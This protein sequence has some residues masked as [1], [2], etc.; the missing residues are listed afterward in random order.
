MDFFARQD[1]ARRR[2]RI[3]LLL[4]GGAVVAIALAAGFVFLVAVH[5]FELLHG[6]ED[7]SAGYPHG[8]AFMRTAPL[9]AAIGFTTGTILLGTAVGLHRLRAGGR[10]VAALLGGR[11]IEPATGNAAERRFVNIAEEMALAAGVP[12]PDLYVLDGEAALNALAAGRAPDEAVIA[13][14]APCLTELPRGELQALLAHEFG[15]VVGG[16]VSLNLKL[17][18]I[19]NGLVFVGVLGKGLLRA[20]PTSRSFRAWP[21]LFPVVLLGTALT[22]I[23][24]AGLLAAR[25]IKAAILRN[26]EHRAD[27]FAVQFTREPSGLRDVLARILVRPRGSLIGHAGAEYASHMFFAEAVRAEGGPLTS[28]HPPLEE[29]IT[30]IDP[31]FDI[32]K[33][34]RPRQ[35]AYLKALIRGRVR[36]SPGGRPQPS[37]PRSP[38]PPTLAQRV[39]SEVGE[40]TAEHLAYARL[41]YARLPDTARRWLQVPGGAKAAVYAALLDPE[42]GVRRVQYRLLKEAGE[43]DLLAEVFEFERPVWDLQSELKLPL[44]DLALPALRVLSPRERRDFLENVRRLS[45][46]DARTTLFEFVLDIIL[47]HRLSPTPP[48]RPPYLRQSLHHVL[49]EALIVIARLAREGHREEDK[50][51]SAFEAAA[52]AMGVSRHTPPLPEACGNEAISNALGKLRT[53]SPTGRK[54]FLLACATC[55]LHDRVVQVSEM[56]LLRAVAEAL[57]CPTP[58][59]G[60]GLQPTLPRPDEIPQ[61]A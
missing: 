9:L 38:A 35:S 2:M 59:L 44:L 56:E 13:V 3:L 33:F 58:P 24:Q 60:A 51:N 53:L 61:H 43:A 46:A 12:V 15:H 1:E 54:E 16:D 17:M 55:V 29:R 32:A 19:L 37:A 5:A 42:P 40:P 31:A 8:P 21:V 25:L 7:P 10:T 6:I 23:G 39:V 18:G 48:V 11:R 34:L 30:R 20:T 36:K 47:R 28:T 52:E 27:A 57:G 45:R 22:A 41:A 50:A 26:T 4:F 49:P 14:T